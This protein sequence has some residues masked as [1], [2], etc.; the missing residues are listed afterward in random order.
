MI[1]LAALRALAESAARAGGALARDA[2]GRR[3]SVTL[4]P[5]S[6]EVTEVDVAAERA[7]VEHIRTTRPLDR[8]IGEEGVAQPSPAVTSA[9][10]AIYWVIDPIDGTRNFIRGVPT[11]SCSVAAMHAGR[12]VAAAIYDPMADVMYSAVAGG[13]ATAGT[14]RLDCGSSAESVRNPQLLVGIPSAW[15]PD[16]GPFVQAL[17]TRCVVRSLGS[18]THHLVYIATGGI[19]ATIMNNCKLWDIAAGALIVEEAGG[20]VTDPDGRPHF[21][22]D[23]AA[24][25]ACE[26]PTLAGT[27]SA[28]A[29][30]LRQIRAT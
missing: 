7:V 3:K 25:D 29:E 1:D 11:F 5:D 24:F 27:K 21:P 4:K 6:S 9:D 23:L 18:A 28:H 30:L 12:P 2:F 15:R 20:V 19:D 10:S 26:L 13:G 16:R 8:F 22:I 17:L 14:L